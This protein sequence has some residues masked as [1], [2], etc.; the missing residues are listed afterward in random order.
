MDVYAT[1]TVEDPEVIEEI[2]EQGEGAIL[3]IG[4]EWYPILS[5]DT[6]TGAVKVGNPE[7]ITYH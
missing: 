4:F 6:K 5:V 1:I 7:E 2:F 3:Q